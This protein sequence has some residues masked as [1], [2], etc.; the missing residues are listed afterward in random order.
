MDVKKR[1]L[2]SMTMI[3][4]SLQDEEKAGMGGGEDDLVI[5]KMEDFV[6]FFILMV[7]DKGL[8]VRINKDEYRLHIDMKVKGGCF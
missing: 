5:S 3:W 7:V 1:V 4:G 2:E 8:M 6:E